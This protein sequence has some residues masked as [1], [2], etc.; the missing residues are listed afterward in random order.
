L[1]KLHLSSSNYQFF[2]FC[3]VLAPLPW[4]K[5]KGILSFWVVEGEH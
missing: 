2:F 5:M 3:N 4:P 1:G